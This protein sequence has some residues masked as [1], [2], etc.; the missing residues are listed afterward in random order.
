MKSGH[1]LFFPVVLFG[2]V[3]MTLFYKRY[4]VFRIQTDEGSNCTC[5]HSQMYDYEQLF[6]P[7][8]YLGS[9]RVFINF[10]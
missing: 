3:R 6:G 10:K 2:A 7:K 1:C 9:L 4:I 8:F 5:I